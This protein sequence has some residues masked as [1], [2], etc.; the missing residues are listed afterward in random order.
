MTSLI[1]ASHGNFAD[2]LKQAQEMILGHQNFV[3]TCSI[4]EGEGPEDLE[5]RAQN[6]IEQLPSE[7]Q[8]LV[9][10]DLFS[11]TPFNTFQKLYT[12]YEN[13]MTIITGA[14]L[15]MV[16]EAVSGIQANLNPR[17]IAKTLMSSKDT[18]IKSIPEVS[19]AKKPAQ[20]DTPQ[21]VK[22][23]SSKPIIDGVNHW[24][25]KHVRIDSRLL[26]GQVAIAWTKAVR[27]DRIVIVSD[28]VSKDKLRK[29]FMKQAAPPG[30]KVN[31]I[32]ISKF[33]QVYPDARFKDTKSLL[34]FEKPEDIESAILETEKQTKQKVSLPE[35]NVGTMAHADGKT[36]IT[37][38][39]SVDK[40]DIASIDN[41]VNMG[42]EFELRQVPTDTKGDL[43][44]LIK[45]KVGA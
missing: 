12:G 19:V 27:P 17:E 15:P 26:H 20:V 39:V 25:I 22:V 36:M 29:E 40:N 30:V 4:R 6:I 5:K 38:S 23:A 24:N 16:L 28:D 7:E 2:G 11:G 13:R 21:G 41:L 1:I 31:V 14:N 18:F 35:I 32:P 34:L 8:L 45:E 37:K 42:Y 10:V 33:A 3:F 43:V 44:K 9:F